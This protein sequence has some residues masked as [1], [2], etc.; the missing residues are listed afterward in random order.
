MFSIS[1]QRRHLA[2]APRPLSRSVQNSL[3]LKIGYRCRGIQTSCEID[4]EELKYCGSRMVVKM[5]VAM[6]ELGFKEARPWV[7]NAKFQFW[8]S[9]NVMQQRKVAYATLSRELPGC[10][11]GGSCMRNFGSCKV[12]KFRT[13]LSLDRIKIC[14]VPVLHTQ[15]R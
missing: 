1:R 6:V 14:S 5:G 8:P 13:Q 2:N 9:F 15:L 10:C 7:E 12:A 3:V 11:R 4:N